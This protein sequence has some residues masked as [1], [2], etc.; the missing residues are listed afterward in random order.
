MA[1]LD[2]H[3]PAVL[4]HSVLVTHW[5]TQFGARLE[6]NHQQL[7]QLKVAAI[8]HDVGKL[9]IPRHI[10]SKSDPLDAEELHLVRSHAQAGYEIL[11]AEA[12]VAVEV[13]DVVQHHHERLDG[14]G[15][16]HALRGAQISL[17]VRIITL[18]DIY[19]ALVENRSYN[20]RMDWKEALKR[21]AE[22]PARLDMDLFRVFADVVS[23]VETKR[24]AIESIGIREPRT[25]TL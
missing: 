2:R 18:C 23:A 24:E 17:P 16:P 3:D 22:K 21:I 12:V 20:P 4:A 7:Q 1:R 14:S 19:A 15:Y 8:L 9:T 11:R 13:L 5:T 6:V 10:L 25:V